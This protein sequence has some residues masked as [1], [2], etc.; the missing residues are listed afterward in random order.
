M[1]WASQGAFGSGPVVTPGAIDTVFDP[2]AFHSNVAGEYNGLTLATLANLDVL[3]IEDASAGFAKRKITGAQILAPT[4]YTY[5]LATNWLT[6]TTV[7]IEPGR[8][9]NIA[10][11]LVMDLAATT[12]INFAINGA[13]GLDTGALV[14][15][16]WYY[17]WLIGDSTET[18][19]PT[20]IGSLASTFAGLSPNLPA[21]YDR[22]RRVASYRCNPAGAIRE[23]KQLVRASGQRRY[24]WNNITYANTQVLS[25]Y[26]IVAFTTLTCTS[27]IPPTAPLGHFNYRGDSSSGIDSKCY[28]RPVG[29]SVGGDNI[30]QGELFGGD[31]GMFTHEV[32]ASQQL[33]AA[34]GSILSSLDV[35]VCGYDDLLAQ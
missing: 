30:I 11:D 5:G 8:T 13:G 20:V 23:F 33:Q 19:A 32:N 7:N 25:G 31:S 9:K 17:G 4:G 28:F 21:G 34:V 29:A 10:N 15:N 1:S 22:G 3:S 35:A 16:N 24:A 26:S 12:I 18:N 14:A 27:F 6:N 2:N